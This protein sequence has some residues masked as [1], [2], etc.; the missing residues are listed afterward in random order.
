MEDSMELCGSAHQVTMVF[1]PYAETLFDNLARNCQAQHPYQ[2]RELWYLLDTLVRYAAL[3]RKSGDTAGLSFH[4]V[5]IT[6]DG[7]L[8]VIP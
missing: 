8:K 4:S 1:E 2:E 3:F 7:G 6:R 5:V